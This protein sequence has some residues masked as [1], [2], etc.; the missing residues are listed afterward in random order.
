MQTTIWDTYLA[1]TIVLEKHSGRSW[2]ASWLKP[3]HRVLGPNNRLWYYNIWGTKVVNLHHKYEIAVCQDA[4]MEAVR[5][6]SGH[7]PDLH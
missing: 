6:D 7:M 5:Y 3:E 2:L 1:W 4:D